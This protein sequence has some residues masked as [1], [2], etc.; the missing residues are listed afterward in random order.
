MFLMELLGKKKKKICE[1]PTYPATKD[2]LTPKL[3]P[4]SGVP[5]DMEIM[6]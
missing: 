2:C 5:W 6:S 1:Q 3:K 4:G